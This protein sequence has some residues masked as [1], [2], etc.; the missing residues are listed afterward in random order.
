MGLHVRTVRNFVRDGRLK[1]VRVGKQYRIAAGDLAGLTG[2]PPVSFEPESVRRYRYVEVS[3]IIEIDAVS[4]E[5]A[6]RLTNVLM[7]AAKSSERGLTPPRMETIYDEE[8]ARMKVIL[9]GSME[10]NASAF[11]V[12]QAVLE[13]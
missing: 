4:P 10:N 11:R 1:A 13:G 8:R 9:I 6:N 12:I 3:S 7:G 5:T 2:R